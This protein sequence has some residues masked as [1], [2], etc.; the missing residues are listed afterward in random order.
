MTVRAIMD[1]SVTS[2]RNS[3]PS[4]RPASFLTNQALVVDFQKEADGSVKRAKSRNGPE[5]FDD[6]KI[7]EASR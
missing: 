2:L 1:P 4:R 6:G 3:L 7:S 5:E